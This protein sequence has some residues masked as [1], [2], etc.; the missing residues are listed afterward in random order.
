MKK[1]FFSV[2][3]LASFNSFACKQ[4]AQFIAPQ[5]ET[6]FAEGSCLVKVIE[7]SHFTPSMVCPLFA[8]EVISEGFM[9]ETQE[10][11]CQKISSI[12]GYLVRDQYSQAIL[13]D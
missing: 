12:S 1:V 10:E 13:F 4:E 3:I 11:N 2:L 7:F 5:V 6:S 9:I 8:E